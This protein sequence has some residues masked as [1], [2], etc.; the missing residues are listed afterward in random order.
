MSGSSVPTLFTATELSA[1]LDISRHEFFLHEPRF[2]V[3]E[4]RRY[5][6]VPVFSVAMLPDALKQRLQQQK[7]ERDCGT[8]EELVRRAQQDRRRT[9]VLDIVLYSRLAPAR[10]AFEVQRVMDVYFRE[11]DT[12]VA[13]TKA[14]ATAR[15]RWIRIFGSRCS[16]RTIRRIAVRVQACGGP[17]LAPIDAY[18][19]QKS[20]PHARG[21]KAKHHEA[22]G[23]AASLLPAQLNGSSHISQHAA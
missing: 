21:G 9:A 13:E 14:N 7:S 8:V 22:A 12:G 19:D 10:D 6:E 23:P 17:E 4:N 5:G 15:G 2:N 11:L 20:I 16:E 1:A 18:A 3:L